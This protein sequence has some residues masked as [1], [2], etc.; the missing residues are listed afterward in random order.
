MHFKILSRSAASRESLG[1]INTNVTSPPCHVCNVLCSKSSSLIATSYAVFI[2]ASSSTSQSAQISSLMRLAGLSEA[3]HHAASNNDAGVANV[4]APHHAVVPSCCWVILLLCLLIPTIMGLVVLFGILSIPVMIL[5][6]FGVRF[7]C[8]A[9]QESDSIVIEV[10][11]QERTMTRCEI[12]KRLVRCN[13]PQEGRCEICLQDLHA[14][15]LSIV[16]SPNPQ[17]IHC[18]HD[19][20]VLE[21]ME[22]NPTCPCCR[23][24]YLKMATGG[25][26]QQQGRGE[27]NLPVLGWEWQEYSDIEHGQNETVDDE[28]EESQLQQHGRGNEGEPPEEWDV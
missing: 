7:I 11:P 19:E 2:M 23:A 13:D 5:A 24:P 25:E 3:A 9:R 28:L 10:S 22:T 17:C 14:P 6:C 4:V 26:S 16:K 8:V 12:K 20:C 15:L 21:W 27:E 18:F 1:G